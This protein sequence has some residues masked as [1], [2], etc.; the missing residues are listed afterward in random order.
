MASA[1]EFRPIFDD[2]ESSL[3]SK[4]V[5]SVNVAPE[6]T[7]QDAAREQPVSAVQSGYS[8]VNFQMNDIQEIEIGPPGQRSRKRFKTIAVRDLHWISRKA[9]LGCFVLGVV[10]MVCHHI[11]YR[12][13]VGHIVGGVTEQLLTRVYVSFR[14][15]SEFFY[16]GPVPAT[17]AKRRYA[18]LET[19][20]RTSY[21]SALCYQSR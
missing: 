10:I 3:R 7:S 12:S 5:S 19:F 4:S 21:K 13:R 6:N 8:A 1:I 11:Y 20:S 2:H 15:N 18:D 9:M 16:D 14:L 17:A